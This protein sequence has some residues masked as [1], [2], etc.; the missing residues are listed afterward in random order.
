MQSKVV[1]SGGEI[2]LQKLQKYHLEEAASF[3]TFL[4]A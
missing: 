4:K 2:D 3:C 1:E